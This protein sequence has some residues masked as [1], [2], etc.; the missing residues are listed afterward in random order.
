MKILIISQGYWPENFRIT[1]IA[2]SLVTQG[3]EVTVLTGLPNVPDGKV[4]EGYKDKRNYVQEHNGVHIIRAKTFGRRHG[5]FFRFL[6]YWS[7]QHYASRL[8]KRLDKDFD[9]VLN[10]LGASV[11][12]I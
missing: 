3:N 1:S 12:K 2:D 8:I 7:F 10:S 9:V 5:I 4:Y 6:N 11:K